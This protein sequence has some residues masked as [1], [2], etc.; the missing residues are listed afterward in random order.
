[1][2]R[3]IQNCI[4]N[5]GSEIYFFKLSLSL[6]LSPPLSLCVTRKS[7]ACREE[8]EEAKHLWQNNF[9]TVNSEL[10]EP[11]KFDGSKKLYCS[12]G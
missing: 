10:W 1:M 4:E 2:V 12:Y 6:P 8:I 11:R 3:S 5:W 9:G 7:T